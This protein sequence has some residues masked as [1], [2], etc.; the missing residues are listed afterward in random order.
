M[1]EKFKSKQKAVLYLYLGTELGLEN[2][3]WFLINKTEIIHQGKGMSAALYELT[4]DYKT[5]A[6]IRGEKASLVSI[7]APVSIKASDYPL[8][9]E[10]EVLEDLTNSH[11]ILFDKQ[12]SEF[13][14]QI[15]SFAILDKQY[16]QNWQ[17]IFAEEKIFFQNFYLDLGFLKNLSETKVLIFK[18]LEGQ[19]LFVFKNSTGA[20]NWLVWQNDFL[21]KLPPNLQKILENSN[22]KITEFKNTNQRMARIFEDNSSP[23][24][25]KVAKV[26]PNLEF[27]KKLAFLKNIKKPSL[28]FLKKPIFWFSAVF[29]SL[30]LAYFVLQ[31]QIAEKTAIAQFTSVNSLKMNQNISTQELVD[32]IESGAKNY[33]LAKTRINKIYS[34]LNRV[35]SRLSNQITPLEIYWDKE[36]LV[37]L[38]SLS[39]EED[40][41]SLQG[42]T[43]KLEF[44]DFKAKLEFNLN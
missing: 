39:S 7:E 28:N 4:K 42:L 40:L 10:D 3:Y 1:F 5:Y 22:I 11:I 25:I 19:S 26:K 14:G 27:G 24:V 34:I 17:N 43:K 29:L 32:R 30:M 6:I 37:F 9:L 12:K 23:L 36:K 15:L 31:N 44:L 35:N 18:D 41:E 2:I 8:F 38:L 16:V 33:P 13:Q 20:L 21:N